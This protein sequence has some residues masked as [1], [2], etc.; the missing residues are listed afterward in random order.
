L[1][2]Q[3]LSPLILKFL[4]TKDPTKMCALAFQLPKIDSQGKFG[5]KW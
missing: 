2:F 4:S 3:I 5:E 1:Q